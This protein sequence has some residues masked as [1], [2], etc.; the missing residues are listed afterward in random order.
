MYYTI[1]WFRDGGLVERRFIL[2]ELNDS[3]ES[4]PITRENVA[5]PE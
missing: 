3:G 5:D 1:P 2:V 4:A